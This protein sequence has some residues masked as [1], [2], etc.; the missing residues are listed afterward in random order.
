MWGIY[1]YTFKGIFVQNGTFSRFLLQEVSFVNT[2]EIF[3]HKPVSLKITLLCC[4]YSCFVLKR[5]IAHHILSI[6]IYQE[7]K[8]IRRGHTRATSCEECSSLGYAFVLLD[9]ALFVKF[10]API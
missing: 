5:I 3:P 1:L 8:E 10:I 7:H 2:F 9:L 6:S 4:V